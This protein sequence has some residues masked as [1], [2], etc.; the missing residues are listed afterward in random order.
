MWNEA[1]RAVLDSIGASLQSRGWAKF[2][3][4]ERLIRD[5]Q[6]VARR[7]GD[8]QDTVDDYTN[9][10]TA[11]DGLAIVLSECPSPLRERL[12]PLID[13]AD[14]CFRDGTI[15][16][17]EGRLSRFFRID[18]DSGWWWKRR[19]RVGPLADYLLGAEKP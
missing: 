16:D 19:P 9:D 1:E 5:W 7:A 14:N 4:V 17:Q 6:R 18:H 10:L 13:D 2:I 11:R 3:T 15:D 12:R 8:Y